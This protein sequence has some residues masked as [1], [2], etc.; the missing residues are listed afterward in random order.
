[1]KPAFN[2]LTLDHIINV[3]FK[4]IAGCIIWKNL[5]PSNL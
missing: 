3:I 5:K 4:C 2:K 1:M